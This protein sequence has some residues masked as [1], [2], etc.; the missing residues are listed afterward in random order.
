[1]FVKI[2]AFLLFLLFVFVSNVRLETIELTT[3]ELM[4]FSSTETIVRRP[5][6][7]ILGALTLVEHAEIFEGTTHF[8]TNNIDVVS[9]S[10]IL[11]PNPLVII[12]ELCDTGN[13]SQA[14]VIIAGHTSDESDLTLTAMA[15]VS[16]YYHIPVITVAS[17]EN[18]FSDKVIRNDNENEKQ[19]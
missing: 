10:F 15:Y 18:I 19:N 13:R 11:K 16:D 17:R 12:S 4:N 8:S 3:S 5:Q 1:M 6:V 7:T 9:R 2:F 14:K